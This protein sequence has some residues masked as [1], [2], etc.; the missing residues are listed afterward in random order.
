MYTYYNS[1][2]TAANSSSLLSDF[3]STLSQ[4]QSKILIISD[5]LSTAADSNPN[6]NL[7]NTIDNLH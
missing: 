4:F 5:S 1:L 3:L 7:I 6:P 2:L